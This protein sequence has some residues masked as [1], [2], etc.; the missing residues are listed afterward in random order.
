MLG[1][2]SYKIISGHQLQVSL[3]DEAISVAIIPN[4][5]SP[6]CVMQNSYG[7]KER[8]KNFHCNMHGCCTIWPPR[9]RDLPGR[10]P[11]GKYKR[12]SLGLSHSILNCLHVSLIC[13]AAYRG[14]KCLGVRSCLLY[15]ALIFGIASA[16]SAATQEEVDILFNKSN[17][18][19]G[20]SNSAKDA[21]QT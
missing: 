11:S 9:V 21:G 10:N 7:L 14:M 1:L 16:I 4:V 6:E 20:A 8:Q 13:A 12:E 3:H 5:C 17:G 15:M 18:N 2:R 19:A